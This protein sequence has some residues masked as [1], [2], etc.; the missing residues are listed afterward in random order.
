MYARGDW[1]SGHACHL[2]FQVHALWQ[3][4]RRAHAT[5]TFNLPRLIKKKLALFNIAGYMNSSFGD[6]VAVRRRVNR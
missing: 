5:R 4:V 6:T 2:R 3:P 1:E